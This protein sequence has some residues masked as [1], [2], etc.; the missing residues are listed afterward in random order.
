M[1]ARRSNSAR[2]H[3]NENVTPEKR[4]APSPRSKKCLDLTLAASPKRRLVNP[5]NE[6][7]T[8]TEGWIQ[9]HHGTPEKDDSNSAN[10]PL[11]REV[12]SIQT[13]SPS[14]RSPRTRASPT[15]LA[16]PVVT[17]SPIV[18]ASF[19]VSP[20][21]F[22]PTPYAPPSGMIQSNLSSLATPRSVK[23][24]GPVRRHSLLSSIL[25][26]KSSSRRRK[27][28]AIPDKF[29]RSSLP[30]SNKPTLEETAKSQELAKA[31]QSIGRV[32]FYK[33]KPEKSEKADTANEDDMEKESTSESVGDNNNKTDENS[34]AEVVRKRRPSLSLKNRTIITPSKRKSEVPETKSALEIMKQEMSS[35][36]PKPS[37]MTKPPVSS[38]LH[39][40]STSIT[41]SR[42]ATVGRRSIR[43]V[44]RKS[45]DG[46]LNFGVGHA[47]KKPR[48]NN[49]P[50][51][52]SPGFVE[53][54]VKGIK[55]IVSPREHTQPKP[56]SK[57][58]TQTPS[59]K[60]T[61][62]QLSMTPHTKVSYEMKGGQLVF[63]KTPKTPLR[64]SPRKKMNQ[65]PISK[66]YFSPKPDN[67]HK[68]VRTTP[69]LFSPELNYLHPDK[70]VSPKK[71]IPSPVKFNKS[72]EDDESM[73]G[74]SMTD[75]LDTLDNSQSALVDNEQLDQSSYSL[76]NPLQSSYP[77]YATEEEIALNAAPLYIQPPETIEQL[78]EVMES[79]G[80]FG[81]PISEVGAMDT[82]T[83]MFDTSVVA[84][85]VVEEPMPTTAAVAVSN[86]LA[87]MSS[88]S[89]SSEDS[90][91]APDKDDNI[92]TSPSKM[93]PIFYKS[94][95]QSEAPND[96][97]SSTEV[98][99]KKFILGE[100]D[101]TQR[102]IDAGQKVIGAT[103][104][105]TCGTVYSVGDP[106]DELQHNNIHS[107]MLEKLNYGGWKHERAV[108]EFPC[109][110]VIMV[111][112]E[113]PIYM[114]RKVE[115]VLSI[116][117]KDL[118]FSEVG[119][120]AKHQTKAFLFIADRKVTGMLLAESVETGH[121]MIPNNEPGKTAKVYCCSEEP[122]PII[123]GISRIWVL[124][125]YRR[126]KI[127]SSLVD[128]FR[129]Q[130]VYGR[131]LREHEFA[132]SDPTLNGIDFASK[133]M[134][135]QE[136]MVYNR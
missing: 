104:C 45:F 128:C 76:V 124:A 112:P 48:Y 1:A 101:H 25:V 127:A 63:R 136:F 65:S 24:L 117:D 42:R 57:T 38:S 39:R 53:A 95:A 79:T 58:S 23:S 3:Q 30:T 44:K 21:M 78:L 27:H 86:I 114:W 135:S 26:K 68:H 77:M 111:Q 66:S 130:F 22:A 54:K 82:S 126:K 129:S 102:I 71:F 61:V 8:L 107:G 108:G 97:Q 80:Q 20:D 49:K 81:P 41:R 40:R 74:G 131:Y 56:G 47:I 2:N 67:S 115:D 93:F 72:S 133:Y 120:R 69:K 15:V 132:F 17:A 28:Q 51:T 43:G 37:S 10:L 6:A 113:D 99:S 59:T 122:K 119:I 29:K 62:G 60:P 55:P 106:T 9:S 36:N 88:N 7:N 70:T 5:L 87:N 123:C 110:R 14:R 32:S 4:A 35:V 85:A 31:I 100:T 98:A 50:K 109:G 121:R 89:C 46:S 13:S 103:L 12:L 75:I 91:E 118:G 90:E 134:A 16:S 92:K 84:E 52:E 73:E 19:P 96:T 34:E 116:V 83:D 18:S 64:R 94:T 11:S 125:D 33:S 105:L